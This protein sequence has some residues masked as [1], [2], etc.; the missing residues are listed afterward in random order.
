MTTPSLRLQELG[1]VLPDVP[2]RLGRYAPGRRVGDV[3][4]LSGQTPQLPDDRVGVLGTDLDVAAGRQAARSAALYCLALLR[5]IT[6]DLDHV[7]SVLRLT[8]YVASTSTF[9]D[10]PAVIDG[11]SE[12]LDQVFGIPHARSALGVCS[13]PRRA[14]VQLDRD[15]EL[16]PG[17][18]DSLPA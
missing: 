18:R 5:S 7:R 11:A 9:A 13:L 10:H 1:V 8:G 3:L 12:V 14:P 17:A 15:V 2:P 6:G 4:Y 16:V